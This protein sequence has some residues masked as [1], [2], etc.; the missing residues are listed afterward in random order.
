MSIV[1]TLM[2]RTGKLT[3]TA[4][5][6]IRDF[7]FCSV[8]AF[9]TLEFIANFLNVQVHERSSLSSLFLPYDPLSPPSRRTASPTTARR[10]T[11]IL[12]RLRVCCCCA[13][14]GAA[15]G[16]RDYTGHDGLDQVFHYRSSRAT[17]AWHSEHTL[18]RRGAR[19]SWL[20]RKLPKGDWLGST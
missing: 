18:R 16:Q 9:P 7:S 13:E 12:L 19:G 6:M 17:A 20:S 15:G 5:L 3:R 1:F 10:R 4:I 2:E 11:N 8:L 14:A